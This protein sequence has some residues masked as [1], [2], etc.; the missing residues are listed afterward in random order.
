MFEWKNSESK[1]IWKV[2]VKSEGVEDVCFVQRLFCV[3]EF[4]LKVE[5]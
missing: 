3:K 1:G 2:K 4:I 5:Q